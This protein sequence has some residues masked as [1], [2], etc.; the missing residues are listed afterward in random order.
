M[1]AEVGLGGGADRLLD[2]VALFADL[3]P[4]LV[5]ALA[6]RSEPI[7]VRAGEVVMHQGDV[8]DG[9]FVVRTGRLR[10]EVARRDGQVVIIGRAGH[11]EVVGEMALISDEPRAATVVAD[12]DS[13]LVRVPTA[14]FDEL[15]ARDPRVPRRV[16]TYLATRMRAS[17][18][19]APPLAPLRTVT[20]VPLDGATSTAAFA[21]L[22]VASLAARVPGSVVAGSDRA[23]ADLGDGALTAA[24]AD[25]DGAVA[26]WADDLERGHPLVVF[27]A[28]AD[29]VGWAGR[30]IRQSDVVVAVAGLRSHDG[31]GAVELA[32]TAHRSGVE[33]R[34]ELVLVRPDWVEDARGTA[35][36]L[37]RLAV[38]RHHQVRE[39]RVDDAERVARLVLGTGVALVLS[40]GGARGLAEIGVV[41]AVQELGVPVDV[42]AG[43]SIGALV[44]GAV[45]R[46]WN[47][48]RIGRSVREG[49]TVGR[50]VVD[51]TLPL[52]A[53]AAGR[54][55]T[56]RLRAAS[57]DLDLEDLHLDFTCVSTNLSRRTV[58][59]HRRG[60]AWRAV[61]ASLAIPGLFPPVASGPDVLVDGGLMENFPVSRVRER[62]PGATVIGVDVGARRDLGSKG[63]PESC[64]LATWEAVR[65]LTRRGARREVNLVRVLARLT[66]LGLGDPDAGAV[67]DVLVEPPVRDVPILAFDRYDEL[68]ARGYEEARR[69]LEPWVDRR[70]EAGATW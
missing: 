54:R 1:G 4:A 26:R 53:L 30:C 55:V 21:G 18:Q 15:A 12:R 63:L 43:T 40:G 10:A 66:E 38:D 9:L 59:V 47:W 14:A 31:V 29:E 50:G 37:E 45:A 34:S 22:V 19:G 17:I 65:S 6:P 58:E 70:A 8:A 61:R 69:V 23:R 5:E 48:E 46:G 28:A 52:L 57:D 49:V 25:H 35:A 24:D 39:G 68:V 36:W 60:E 7:R 13:E 41:R 51:P 20:V 2:D 33:V 32:L 42:V 67:P 44:G 3:D 62:H 27:H 16:A 11:G 56:R 64:E